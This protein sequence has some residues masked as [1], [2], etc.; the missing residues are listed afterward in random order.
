MLEELI[1]VITDEEIRHKAVKIL[2]ELDVA[3]KELSKEQIQVKVLKQIKN[4]YF[5]S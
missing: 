3:R 1:N 5:N 2:T 4:L